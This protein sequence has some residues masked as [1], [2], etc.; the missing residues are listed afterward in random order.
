VAVDAV[1][2]VNVPMVGAGR[3]GHS[4]EMNSLFFMQTLQINDTNKRIIIIIMMI[5]IIIIIIK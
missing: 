2:G 3:A 1:V 5:I 4:E